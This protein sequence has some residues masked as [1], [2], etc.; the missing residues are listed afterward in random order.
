MSISKT[1]EMV[2][3]FNEKPVIDTG[4]MNRIPFFSVCIPTYNRAF[5]LPTAIESVLAQDFT[6]F[7]LV[8]CDNASNDNTEEVVK[9]YRDERIRYVR[10]K[11]LVSMY[12]NHN[13]C[14]ELAQADWLIFL[15]SDDEFEKG[16]FSFYWNSIKTVQNIDIFYSANQVH[17]SIA[18]WMNGAAYH[19]I[20]EKPHQL[21]RYPAGTPSGAVY[22]TDVLR[23]TRFN[24]KSICADLDILIKITKQNHKIAIV[25]QSI[26]QIGT[27]AANRYTN[28]WHLSGYFIK[29]VSECLMD[30]LDDKIFQD[31]LFDLKNWTSRQI[32]LLMLFF[33][34]QRRLDLVEKMEEEISDKS[35]RKKREYRHVL[36]AKLLGNTLYKFL[37]S[38]SKKLRTLSI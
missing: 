14:I 37:Y 6:D 12:A 18:N 15:H 11:D 23:Q 16:S 25:N 31:I 13:R 3:S 21:Y 35:Y 24:E 8:I 30:N 5:S 4:V 22:R 28:T 33:T 10:Y 1:Q 2:R 9:N 26:I 29:D 7:E 19:Y 38:T 32:S 20:V 36:V 17:N 34:Y 27:N